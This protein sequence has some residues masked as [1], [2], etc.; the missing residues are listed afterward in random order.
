MIGR[1]TAALEPRPRRWLQRLWGHPYLHVRQDWH[2]VWPLV[3]RLPE[4][5]LSVLDAGCGEGRWTL[6]LAVRRPK[7]FL[8]G[9]DQNS[10]A[11]RTAEANRRRLGLTNVAFVRGRFDELQTRSRFDLVLSICSAHYIAEAGKGYELFRWFESLLT[12][13]GALILYAPRR[14]SEA[15]FTPYLPRFKWRTVFSSDELRD[16]CGRSRL[17]I[18]TLEGRLGTFGTA[19][20]QLDAL[21]SGSHRRLKLMAGIYPLEWLCQLADRMAVRTPARASLMWL[22][23]ARPAP[24]PVS[25]PVPPAAFR[26]ESSTAPW[27]QP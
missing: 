12:E 24:R 16:Y 23:V 20:K 26:A 9:L 1:S 19:A 18:E 14:G 25:S 4:K 6:E 2:E 10:E 8:V 17:H 27:T 15:P 13:N 11:L 21:A 22:L 3:E 5:G 7:W